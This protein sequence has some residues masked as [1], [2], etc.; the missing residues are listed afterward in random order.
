MIIRVF[1]F[2]SIFIT[3]CTNNRNDECIRPK[4]DIVEVNENGDSNNF[5]FELLN[6]DYRETKVINNKEDYEFYVSDNSE[7]D[8]DFNLYSVIV[9]HFSRGASSDI[10]STKYNISSPC[11]GFE[12]K[13]HITVESKPNTN[14]SS[15]YERKYLVVLS[16]LDP[17]YSIIVTYGLHSV[18]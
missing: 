17:E 8:I 5:Q 7:N 18:Q 9:G 11:E 15:N 16:K 4:I 14:N 13:F 1:I 10:V 2:I 6:I 3:S 12:Y